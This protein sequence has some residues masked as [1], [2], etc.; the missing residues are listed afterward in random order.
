HAVAP[1]GSYLWGYDT[2]SYVRG[3]PALLRNGR[4]LIGNNDGDLVAVNPDGTEGWSLN[5][6]GAI[7]TQEL[8]D[9]A[10]RI[11]IGSYSQDFYCLDS[12][13]NEIW[14]SALP[15]N[16]ISS[17]ATIGADGTV[18]IGSWDGKLYAFGP[19]P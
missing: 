6:S 3:S 11:Y 10:G 19:T 13:G 5:L 2:G 17:S 14:S 9:T 1:D 16:V 8:V 4:I 12:L 7:R 18:Y 15:V